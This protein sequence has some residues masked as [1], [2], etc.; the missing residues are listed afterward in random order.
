MYLAITG[1]QHE[2]SLAEAEAV[3]GADSIT[4]LNNEGFLINDDQAVHLFPRIGGI[5]KLIRIFAEAEASQ[6]S[7]V[8][9]L[10][11]QVD[12]NELI[13]PISKSKI[14]VGISSYGSGVSKKLSYSVQKSI[15]RRLEGA[16]KKTRSVPSKKALSSAQVFHNRLDDMRKGIELILFVADD[17][18]YVGRTVAVQNITAY[19]KRDRSRP[20][21]DTKVGMLPPKLA[22]M[23]VNLGARAFATDGKRHTVLDPF[24]GTG[25]VLMEAALMG[26]DIYGTDASRRMVDYTNE[27]LSWLRTPQEFHM[28]T[29][30][31]D[32]TSHTW[33]HP[34]DMVI[35]E[36]YLGEPL[37]HEASI[38]ELRRL[39]NE[40]K[41]LLTEFLV[42]IGTQMTSGTQL[43]LAIPAWRQGKQFEPALS[44]DDLEKLGYTLQEFKH[45]DANALIYA[46][47]DQF[48]GRKLVALTKD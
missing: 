20:K 31:G 26:F 16:D 36:M 11:D 18:L 33:P 41:H 25:V 17:Q 4:P 13:E 47:D 22:Q 40:N 37:T 12:L 39:Q 32:A 10:L 6:L 45:V 1:R 46:R 24:C 2:L 27:N 48:V 28:E 34:F 8:P 3:F 9:K 30:V 35:S 19:S 5:V 7:Q 43:C 29:E 44:V 42:N 15:E 38:G 14:N 21:R 23:M